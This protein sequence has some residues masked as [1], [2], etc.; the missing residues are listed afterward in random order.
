MGFVLKYICIGYIWCTWQDICIHCV[1]G[2]QFSVRFYMKALVQKT[3]SCIK[4]REGLQFSVHEIQDKETT[5][6][7]FHCH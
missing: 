4:D 2:C 6:P 5:N 7:A 1:E 3:V